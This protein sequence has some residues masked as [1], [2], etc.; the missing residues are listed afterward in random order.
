MPR[1]R[2]LSRAVRCIL[3]GTLLS[4]GVVLAAGVEA[5][6][7]PAGDQTK[8]RAV[9]LRSAIWNTRN[10]PVCWE[11]PA[12]TPVDQQGRA[13]T[14]QAVQETWEHYS[15]LRFVGWQGCTAQSRGIRIRIADE[16]PRVHQMG[17]HLDGMR[18]GMVLN[19]TF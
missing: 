5:K 1:Q 9:A 13:W 18:D 14:R 8:D 19:F 6:K 15:P 10:I 2:G 3:W 16:G 11:N 7:R 17:K 12:E 4:V